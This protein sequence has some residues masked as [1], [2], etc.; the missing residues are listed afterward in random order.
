[1]LNLAPQ[2]ECANNEVTTGTTEAL[3][4]ECARGSKQDCRSDVKKQAKAALG[5][6]C[7]FKQRELVGCQRKNKI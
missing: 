3:K 4:T 7:G 1:L 5:S 6:H 2:D